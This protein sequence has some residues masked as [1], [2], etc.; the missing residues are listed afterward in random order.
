MAAGHR[1]LV[2]SN[3]GGIGLCTFPGRR[4][5]V[6]G[7]ETLGSA[8]PSPLLDPEMACVACANPCTPCRCCLVA[9]MQ[10][11]VS[12]QSCSPP[13][14]LANNHSWLLWQAQASSCIL[15]TVVHQTLALSGWLHAANTSVLPR[16][17]LQS[18]SLSIRDLPAP[19]LEYLRLG[20]ARWWH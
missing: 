11:E 14:V 4:C 17:G 12:R 10:Q 20:C 16:S 19:V 6:T 15:L 2:S 3:D 5:V 18:P 9:C 8:E 1:A 13:L 7:C